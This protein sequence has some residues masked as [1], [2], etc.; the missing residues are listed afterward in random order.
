MN[1]A[2]KTSPS[3]AFPLSLRP[4]SEHTIMSWAPG[5]FHNMFDPNRP[6]NTPQGV[7]FQNIGSSH[8][9]QPPSAAPDQ[10]QQP[11]GLMPSASQGTNQILGRPVF[12]TTASLQQ[13]QT[14]LPPRPTAQMGQA[15]SPNE[16]DDGLQPFRP[17]VCS[18]T[19]FD[20]FS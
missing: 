14:W 5:F 13:H 2:V 18:E 4:P 16:Q 15:E 10:P 17:L 9:A 11:F 19:Y 20:D 6:Q 3:H 8:P 1:A 7:P 12:S